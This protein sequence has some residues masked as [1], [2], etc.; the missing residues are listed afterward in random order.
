[1]DEW[2]H[3]GLAEEYKMDTYFS[4]LNGRKIAEAEDYRK[5]L[6]PTKLLKFVS[7]TDDI[8]SN[9]NKFVTLE[10][11]QAWFSS[12]KVLDDPYEFKGMYI[13]E[14]TLTKNGYPEYLISSY[15]E[16]FAN[17]IEQ[18]SV[19]SLSATSIDCLPMW[20]YYTN[21]FH[22]FCIEY[23]VE[24]P[25]AIL[26]VFYESQRIPIASVMA[27]FYNE[28][29]KMVANEE[30]TNSEVE[31]YATMLKGQLH[32]KHKS[33]KHE[34]EF[35]VL[36]PLLGEYGQNVNINNIGLKPNR[37]IAGLNC[38]DENKT[39]LNNI[40]NSLGCGDL[41]ESKISG[42]KYTIFSK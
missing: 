14:D 32:I 1:M 11:N 41:L 3:S 25:D 23:Q 26:K 19:L 37:I 35:R 10:N 17:Q 6:V 27:N 5:S 16:L 38:N 24:R 30:K 20:A 34:N 31:F 9:N 7:L 21:N 22:G 12:A 33:W 39:R 42:N 40:S 15:K 18:W 4:L 36:Y 28:F 29:N 8:E 13:D 2:I